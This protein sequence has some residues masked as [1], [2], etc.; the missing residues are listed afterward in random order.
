MLG[1][2]IPLALKFAT[3]D[4]FNPSWAMFQGITLC[5]YIDFGESVLFSHYDASF[6]WNLP[7]PLCWPSDRSPPASAI[8]WTSNQRTLQGTTRGTRVVTLWVRLQGA[9]ELVMVVHHIR[10]SETNVL[11]TIDIITR[12]IYIRYAMSICLHDAP[13]HLWISGHICLRFQRMHVWMWRWDTT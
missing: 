11:M 9:P 6:I 5:C 13:H 3:W 2:I 8:V 4:N 7:W 10:D 1:I 12:Y